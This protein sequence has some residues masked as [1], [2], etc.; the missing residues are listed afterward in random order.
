MF[1]FDKVDSKKAIEIGDDLELRASDHDEPERN[2]YA[3]LP[4]AGSTK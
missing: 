1:L 2:H 3:R 4:F